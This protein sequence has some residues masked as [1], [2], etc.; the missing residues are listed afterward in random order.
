VEI[1]VTRK[2][3]IDVF[4]R[5][6]YLFRPATTPRRPVNPAAPGVVNDR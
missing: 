3:A 4:Y 5:K 6:E 2:G 1:K